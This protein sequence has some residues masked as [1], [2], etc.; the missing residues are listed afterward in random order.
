MPWLA[1]LERVRSVRS[2][3]LAGLLMCELFTL[4]VFFWFAQAIGNYTDAPLWLGVAVLLLLAP[5]LQPQWI[6]FAVART[7]AR[8]RGFWF[9]TIAGAGIY[10][11]SERL[12]PKLFADTI[13]HG[14]FASARMRQAA[15]LAG[16]PGLTFL[17][18]AGNEC[19]LALLFSLRRRERAASARPIAPAFALIAILGG[20]LLYGEVRLRQLE[21]GGET[22]ISAALVQGDISHYARLAAES[23]TYDAVRM[24]LDR[25]FSL[26][27]QALESG[28]LDLLVWP[29]TVYP[30]T[31]GRPKSEDGAAFD[32][33]IAAFVARSQ[34][35]L[36][37]GSYDVEDG[38]EYNAAM[39]LV[40]Q[41]SPQPPAPNPRLLL[42]T[43]R[44]TALFP[45]TERIPAWMDS[46]A[47]RDRLPW[48]GA[49]KAGGGPQVLSLT[50][51][52][53]TELT[54]APLICYDAVDP[55]LAIEAARHGAEVI[56]AISNDSWFAEGGGPRLH[57]VV[58]AFRSL[59]TRRTQIRA[60]TTGVS[61]VI[62]ATGELTSTLGVHEQGF[63]LAQMVPAH[64]ASTLMLAW[65]DWFGP[66]AL[67]LGA[68]F[69]A[70]ALLSPPTDA[71][72]R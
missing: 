8:R 54:I 60:T 23:S 37:F 51:R 50:R 42:D 5:V 13:G 59:E 24:I 38:R 34:T 6:A 66:V 25:Y 63:L 41:T 14:L 26:S 18:V 72:R 44:K 49:W 55:M 65:G 16:A 20:L 11:G 12:F 36:L 46:A 28:P 62:T 33:E 45:F 67:A 53:G 15:D 3:L 64:G 40:P 48:A 2:A 22:P 39:L 57:L 1:A 31:F 47:M 9:M 56:V 30:T 19:V 70:A 61:A 32:R 68:A 7:L 17:L 21:T 27:Q 10:T 71:S 58:S 69:L 43:Y 4:A 52:D 35:P 29:E